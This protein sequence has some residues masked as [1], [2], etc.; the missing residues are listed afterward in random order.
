MEKHAVTIMV[1]WAAQEMTSV[2]KTV[3][4]AD[5]QRLP[6]LSDLLA[7]GLDGFALPLPFTRTSVNPTYKRQQTTNLRDRRPLRPRL[8]TAMV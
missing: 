4:T 7:Q 2:N 1:L 8:I 3:E 5:E 6:W